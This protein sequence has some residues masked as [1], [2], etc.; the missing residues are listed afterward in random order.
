V[1]TI[2]AHGLFGRV[3]ILCYMVLVES[4]VYPISMS[5]PW[6]WRMLCSYL[7]VLLLRLRASSAGHL[8]DCVVFEFA[9]QFL[10]YSYDYF[11][12]AARPIQVYRLYHQRKVVLFLTDGFDLV[13]KA[14]ERRMW[15]V[16]WYLSYEVD[17]AYGPSPGSFSH[18]LAACRSF[19]ALRSRRI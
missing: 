1:S 19:T 15:K 3:R 14:R 11:D 12:F 5:T 2:E 17:F 16:A 4:R 10:T 6:R 18:L 9:R 7:I 13:A 8:D